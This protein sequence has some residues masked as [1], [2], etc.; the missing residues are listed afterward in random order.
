MKNLEG[1]IIEGVEDSIRRTIAAFQAHPNRYWNERDLHWIFYHY[2]N[3]PQIIRTTTEAIDLIRAEFPTRERYDGDRGHYDLVIVSPE[4]F[5]SSA[6][7]K[8]K[9]QATWKEFLA[10]LEIFVAVEM[11]IWPERK[12]YKKL[13]EWDIKKLTDPGNKV[14]HAYY[15]NFVQLDFSRSQMQNY[16]GELRD[17]LV[18]QKKQ[19]AKVKI[20]CV[21]SDSGLQN[22]SKNWLCI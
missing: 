3:T 16:Y 13:I 18:D 9:P 10:L 4:S 17:Y 6:V 8:L 14:D 19:F 11:K 1:N 21:A 12:S 22:D 15:L 7:S 2:L 20:V 5:Y